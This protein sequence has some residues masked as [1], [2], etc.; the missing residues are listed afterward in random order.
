MTYKKES[1]REVLVSEHFSVV[2]VEHLPAFF[3]VAHTDV[4]RETDLSY[5]KHIL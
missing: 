5:L 4:L 2:F 1:L 3:A